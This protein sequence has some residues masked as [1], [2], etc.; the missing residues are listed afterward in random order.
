MSKKVK[1][2]K[3]VWKGLL[4]A[5]AIG[6]GMSAGVEVLAQAAPAMQV[7]AIGVVSALTAAIRTGWNLWKVNRKFKKMRLPR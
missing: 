6:G 4:A 2:S 1:I 5:M 3:G 7:T